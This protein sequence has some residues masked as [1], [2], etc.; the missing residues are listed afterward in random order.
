M[1][2]GRAPETGLMERVSAALQ[3]WRPR[4]KGS[5]EHAVATHWDRIVGVAVA[6]NAR[7]RDLQ[8]GALTVVVPSAAWR[9]ELAFHA[10]AIVEALQ[11]LPEVGTRVERLRFKM[12]RAPAAARGAGPASIGRR[13]DRRSAREGNPA[14]QPAADA[15]TAL[16]RLRRRM[17]LVAEEERRSGR[18]PCAA[19]GAFLPRGAAC[20]P[21]ARR[22]LEAIERGVQRHLFEAPWI[23]YDGMSALVAGL[24]FALYARVR[25][26][27]L[28]RWW[29]MLEQLRRRGQPSR[30]GRERKVAQSYVALKSGLAPERLTPVIVR[31]ILGD[32]IHELLWGV[33]DAR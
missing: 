13:G 31:E 22:R 7:P 21:C 10:P 32:Q 30:D 9:H 23:G 11:A 6:A 18:E 14:D 19:C 12:G 33:H 16:A 15:V 20:A 3:R 27:T 1:A 2:D 25:A 24:D 5:P 26:R 4:T 28:E 17:A 8:D 29:R